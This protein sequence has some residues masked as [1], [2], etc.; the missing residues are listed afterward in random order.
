MSCRAYSQPV[1]RDAVRSEGRMAI[2]QS[3]TQSI[4]QLLGARIGTVEGTP[5]I[6]IR[7]VLRHAR[8]SGFDG[9]Q[10]AVLLIGGDPATVDLRSCTLTISGGRSRVI[11]LVALPCPFGGVRWLASCPACHRRAALLFRL[12]RD[13]VWACRRCHGL[14]HVTALAN[15]RKREEIKVARLRMRLGLRVWSDGPL[16]GRAPRMR[17]STETRLREALRAAEQAAGV[18]R[19]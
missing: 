18:Q 13:A 15:R 9:F 14:H 10:R 1:V 6:D 2:W 4:W 16:P 11:S 7:E 3:Q 12:R 8:A 5:S 19:R 17:R